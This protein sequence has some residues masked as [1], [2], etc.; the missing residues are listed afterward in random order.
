MTAILIQEDRNNSIPILNI[1]PQYQKVANFCVC[2]YTKYLAWRFFYFEASP[3]RLHVP[4]VFFTGVA[5]KWTSGLFSSF[6]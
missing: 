6:F 5:T 1:W 3:V 4:I 2:G